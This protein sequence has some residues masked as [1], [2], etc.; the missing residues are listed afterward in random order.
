VKKSFSAEKKA[1]ILAYIEKYTLKKG[2]GA[3][4]AA[5]K[6]FKVSRVTLMNWLKGGIGGKKAKKPI[7]KKAKPAAHAPRKVAKRNANKNTALLSAFN[8]LE[9]GAAE[10]LK[11]LKNSFLS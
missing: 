10:F 11:A 8:N 2:R 9:K 1:E 5:S 4:S 7:V 3:Q 6:K